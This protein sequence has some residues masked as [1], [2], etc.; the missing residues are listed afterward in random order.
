LLSP[1]S[2]VFFDIFAM[3]DAVA[4]CLIAADASWLIAD[5]TPC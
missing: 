4:A 5:I 1:L 3:L 2:N